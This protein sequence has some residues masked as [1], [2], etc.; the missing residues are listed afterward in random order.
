MEFYVSISKGLS[1][2]SAQGCAGIYQPPTPK[3][4]YILGMPR[5]LAFCIKNRIFDLRRLYPPLGVGGSQATVKC[6]KLTPTR[7][8]KSLTCTN[9]F[10][11][12]THAQ[13]ENIGQLHVRDVLILVQVWRLVPAPV[14]KPRDYIPKMSLRCLKRFKLNTPKTSG[15]KIDLFLNHLRH[16]RDISVGN[17]SNIFVSPN[18]LP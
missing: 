12:L 11:S 17:E 5:I 18:P 8:Y 13:R 14:S 7:W 10:A 2:D 6:A 4:E 16:L 3:G 1:V 15:D 9:I